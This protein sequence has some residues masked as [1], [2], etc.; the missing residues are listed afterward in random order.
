MRFFKGDFFFLVMF[1]AFCGLA[2]VHASGS[3]AFP[4]LDAWHEAE[5]GRY[6]H[7]RR[8]ENLRTQLHQVHGSGP[9]QSKLLT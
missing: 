4:V 8:D 9:A 1:L 7:E 3:P 5:M 2:K 6:G